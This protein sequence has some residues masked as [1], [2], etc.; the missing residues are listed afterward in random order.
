MVHAPL[1]LVTGYLY[2]TRLSSTGPLNISMVHYPLLLAHWL[3]LWYTPIF[4]R[5]T[6]CLCCT[7]P[8]L[9]SPPI[10]PMIHCFLLLVTGYYHFLLAH[11]Q[12]LCN[13]AI[14][15]WPS[16]HFY[17]NLPFFYWPTGYPYVTVFFFLLG[18]WISQWYTFLSYWATGYLYGTLLSS[19]V[20]LAIHMVHFPLL[21]AN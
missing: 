12:S 5:P 13:T 2:G 18:N 1:L 8:S 14:F 6:G 19:T 21:L 7:L 10:I 16:G 4:Y 17:G 3:S 20:L 15:Y 11:W 9:I